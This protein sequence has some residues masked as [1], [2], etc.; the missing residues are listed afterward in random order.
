MPHTVIKSRYANVKNHSEISRY[1]S[2]HVLP[3][4]LRNSKELV[5]FYHFRLPW[6]LPGQQSGCQ[7]PC[8]MITSLNGNIFRVT[9]HLCGE[10][11]GHRWISHTKARDAELWFFFNLCLNKR[12]S[13]QSLGWCFETPSPHYDVIVMIIGLL[14]R[15]RN[16]TG[17][18]MLSVH[19]YL[20]RELHTMKIWARMDVT[21]KWYCDKVCVWVSVCVCACGGGGWG[22]GGV[23]GWGWGGG[24]GWG[25][26]GVG[27]GGWGGGGGGGGGVKFLIK[28]PRKEH[29]P[30][31]YSTLQ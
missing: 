8:I 3:C 4:P 23:G 15:N 17:T 5:K 21:G 7:L 12:L 1:F 27:G 25:V 14:H 18:I 19:T 9:G 6:R 16:Q 26:G 11:T 2:V 20:K 10:F 24:G 29:D 22:G 13:K 31:P 28:T 30:F